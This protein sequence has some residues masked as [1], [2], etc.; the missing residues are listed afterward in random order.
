MDSCKLNSSKSGEHLFQHPNE[1]C[2][3]QLH[4]KNQFAF[5]GDTVRLA[6]KLESNSQVLSVPKY[7]PT[8]VVSDRPPYREP[9]LLTRTVVNVDQTS[10]RRGRRQR[11][12]RQ[13][14]IT[15]RPQPIDRGLH[16]HPELGDKRNIVVAGQP[17]AARP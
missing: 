4:F 5:R 2:L 9:E 3:W 10:M 1:L 7:M 17:M 12:E 14:Q 15:P 16:V 11:R 6:P 13:C 8:Y